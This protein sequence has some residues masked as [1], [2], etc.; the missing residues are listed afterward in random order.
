M[1]LERHNV[2]NQDHLERSYLISL[3][4]TYFKQAPTHNVSFL[5]PIIS[6]TYLKHYL[7][8]LVIFLIAR[9]HAA[10]PRYG[11]QNVCYNIHLP[12]V[13]RCERSGLLIALTRWWPADNLGCLLACIHQ[14]KLHGR[15]RYVT[16]GNE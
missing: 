7:L 11:S 12:F 4:I 9:S 8:K 6:L 5:I 3:P 10:I 15:V 13:L 14:V 2:S 16:R 1:S